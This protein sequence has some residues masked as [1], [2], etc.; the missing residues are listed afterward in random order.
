MITVFETVTVY[1]TVMVYP[2]I[3]SHTEPIAMTS[4]CHKITAALGSMAGMFMVIIAMVTVGYVLIWWKME[5]K[6]RLMIDSKQTR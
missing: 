5:K 6:R 4:S 1:T 2:S 3:T